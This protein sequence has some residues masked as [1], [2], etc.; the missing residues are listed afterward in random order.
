MFKSSSRISLAIA[1]LCTKVVANSLDR[2]KSE[3][4]NL[5]LAASERAYKISEKL[6]KIETTSKSQEV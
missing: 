3:R 2:F 6:N 4:Q 1:N 5:D